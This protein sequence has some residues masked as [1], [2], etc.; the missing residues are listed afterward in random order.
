MIDFINNMTVA[1]SLAFA[2]LIFW[3]IWYSIRSV[4]KL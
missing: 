4:T 3:A 2:A 1:D